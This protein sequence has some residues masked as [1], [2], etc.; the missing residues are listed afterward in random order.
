M[1]KGNAGP[2]KRCRKTRRIVGFNFEP[3]YM[4]CLFPI[5]G[6]AALIWVIVRVLPKPSRLTYPC[7]QLAAPLASSFLAYVGYGTA[8][9]FLMKWFSEAKRYRRQLT[10][11]GIVAIALSI[12]AV[13]LAEDAFTLPE[14][15]LGSN[16]PVGTPRGIVPGRVAWVHDPA[17][18][19][20][21][22]RDTTETA[23]LPKF[24]DPGAANQ[25]NV[26]AMVRDSV[27]AVA[28]RDDISEAWDAVFKSFNTRRGKGDIGYVAGEKIAIKV[29]MNCAQ[30]D[31]RERG[32]INASPHMAAALLSSL[33]NDAGIAPEHITLYDSSRHLTDAIYD[34]CASYH[35]NVNYVENPHSGVH[36]EGRTKSTYV[37]NVIH[38]SASQPDGVPTGIAA[39]QY[40]ADYS[41]NMAILK[42]H[43]S[44]PTL[45][46]KNWFGALDIS[47][48]ISDNTHPNWN[49][50]GKRQDGTD[51][52]TVVEYMAH[53]EIG[54]KTM[55]FFVEGLFAAHD[56]WAKPKF[57]WQNA[58]FNSQFPAT[59]LASQDMVAID[60]VASDFLI[61][62]Y[63]WDECRVDS[64]KAYNYD[65]YDNYLY[66]AAMADNPPSGTFYDP[67]NDS[68]RAKSLGVFE[69]WNNTAN[70]E[71]T[72]NLG[73]QGIQ[74]YKVYK[75][76]VEQDPEGLLVIQAESANK[77]NIRDHQLW[78]QAT[79]G[80]IAVM[81]TS[82]D[83]QNGNSYLSDA[84]RLDYGVTF[85]TTGIHYVW[86]RA[87]AD[88]TNTC[89]IGLDYK[90]GSN[91]DGTSK[92]SDRVQVTGSGD[93]EWTSLAE[94]GSVLRVYVPTEGYHVINL[95]AG[96]GHFSIDRIH[97][98]NDEAYTPGDEPPP[99]VVNTLQTLLTE[100]PQ[101]LQS[102]TLEW[103]V[104]ADGT[105]SSVTNGSSGVPTTG[106]FANASGTVAF[107]WTSVSDY[108]EEQN[109]LVG[110]TSTAP[111]VKWGYNASKDFIGTVTTDS[112]QPDYNMEA[113]EAILMRLDL[114]NFTLD[115]G[116]VLRLDHLIWENQSGGVN[117]AGA[118]VTYYDESHHSPYQIVGTGPN[119][120]PVVAGANVLQPIN[121]VVDSAD[122]M[123]LWREAGFNGQV[124]LA[125][126]QFSVIPESDLGHITL[127]TED[128]GN[129]ESDTL[130]WT[131]YAD[132]TGTSVIDG[133]AAVPTLG[134][135]RHASGDFAFTWTAEYN[136]NETTFE[137]GLSD[138]AGEKWSYSG[139]RR[140]NMGV[141]TPLDS[142]DTPA[143]IR[144][145]EAVRMVIDLSNL[146]L[147]SGYVL[148]LDSVYM[149]HIQGYSRVDVGGRFSHL[150]K[151]TT[152]ITQLTGNGS[153][154][155]APIHGEF[156]EQPIHQI[157]DNGD[158]IALW[159]ESGFTDGS[160]IRIAGFK[161]SVIQGV[162]APD[163]TYEQW[164]QIHFDSLT[165]A[166]GAPGFDEDGDGQSNELEWLVKTDPKD[167]QDFRKL[168]LAVNGSDEVE[169][170]FDCVENRIITI[171]ESDD[172][173][174]WNT[175][176]DPLN[177]G[178]PASS[179]EA[180]CIPV[181][182]LESVKF[183][184]MQVTS[185]EL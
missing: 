115:S 133:N 76:P 3:W 83:A 24:Y 125:G 78:Q 146:T 9:A 75:N 151:S 16:N 142:E 44:V 116:Y 124:R 140:N 74:L 173:V 185:R 184:R 42:G 172:L 108:A 45:C 181:S 99:P 180:L 126:F 22:D 48:T 139:N 89:H 40:E 117:D 52:A 143:K 36:A 8:V 153:G 33:I 136:F 59:L 134:N 183:Y 155:L 41:I 113:G 132:G 127:F 166:E 109:N 130:V 72:G 104:Y 122:E 168:L 54:E 147:D 15:H 63:P 103:T 179:T 88:A 6:I 30:R 25:P 19:N 87:K 62:E 93:Y 67:E 79:D 14:T 57:H 50:R 1:K 2:F 131:V 27:K 81:E 159:R 135:L 114:T 69:H 119:Q 43:G 169:L 73:G 66:E 56:T 94:N 11:G 84:P 80:S 144:D 47:S 150:D 91:S 86:V 120:I 174:G 96:N 121:Q 167:P 160:Q 97:I 152:L 34:Y 128:P 51:Y 158:E 65:Y 137:G 164:R 141:I 149:R 112:E 61:H 107:T 129:A 13:E 90:D 163:L 46:A 49:W 35:P 5:L 98:S 177:T 157:V 32:S 156:V 105:A 102:A 21:I 123:A 165:S 101:N 138:V 55:L 70:R 7:I 106:S 148:R 182:T 20:P 85:N 17:A 100:S 111:G 71:Y 82:A 12:L 68:V 60:S 154:Q 162:G 38:Y 18:I 77:N 23:G 161:F 28:A 118:R 39:C 170:R 10:A 37:T 53:E 4:K 175:L 31:H 29:N 58:P 171:E 110:T 145:G 95:W 178:D 26:D 64:E 92:L 176:E